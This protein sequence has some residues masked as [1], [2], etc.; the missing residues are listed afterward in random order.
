MKTITPHQAKTHLARYLA[1]TEHGEIFVIARGDKPIA[2]LTPIPE[3]GPDSRPQAS[4]LPELPHTTRHLTLDPLT[5]EE[6]K[7]WYE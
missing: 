6:L 4:E 5:E 7:A 3:L 1:A 2:L